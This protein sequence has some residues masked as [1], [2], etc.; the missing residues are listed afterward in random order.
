MHVKPHFHKCGCLQVCAGRTSVE[1]IRR[2]PWRAS[3]P[4][5]CDLQPQSPCSPLPSRKPCV[6]SSP[7]VR[8]LLSFAGFSALTVIPSG[9][10][11]AR[12]GRRIWEKQAAPEKP[13]LLPVPSHFLP[14]CLQFSTKLP[15]RQILTCGV[16]SAKLGRKS[17]EFLIPHFPHFLSNGLLY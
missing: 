9:L 3:F 14:S 6:S 7:S 5:A 17:S 12:N 10:P 2:F 16:S 8:S 13:F 4:G 15:S 11:G 1:F